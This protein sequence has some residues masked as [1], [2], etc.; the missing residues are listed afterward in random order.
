MD[1]DLLRNKR[2]LVVED[3]MLVLMGIEDMLS[4]LGCTAITVAGTVETALASI[5]ANIFD[6]AMLDVNLDGTPSY[7]VADALKCHHI[8][9]A[10]STGYGGPGVQNGYGDCPVLNKPY[11]PGQ[12]K[13]VIRQ[14][15]TDGASPAVAA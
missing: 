4:D 14:L 12:L 9:F 2:V 6:F 15:M 11:S 7:A 13:K 10:F 5:A 3:E 1:S 8:P